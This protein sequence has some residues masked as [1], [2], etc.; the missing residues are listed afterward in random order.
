V[1]V[2]EVATMR[3]DNRPYG[4]TRYSGIGREGPRYAMHEMSE[5]RLVMFNL[6]R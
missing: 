3:G 2:N 5:P 6:D 4:G 1:M